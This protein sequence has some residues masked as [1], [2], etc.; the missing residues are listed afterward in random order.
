MRGI[1]TNP[2]WG[3]PKTSWEG[4][5][6]DL[7]SVGG[8]GDDPRRHSLSRGTMTGEAKVGR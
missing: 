1:E 4:P 6:Q 2:V 3:E 7:P 8:I 5:E